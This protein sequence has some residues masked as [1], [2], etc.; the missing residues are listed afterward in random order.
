[1]PTIDYSVIE[2]LEQFMGDQAE[3]VTLIDLFLDLAPEQ[4]NQVTQ[5]WESRD[6][7]VLSRCA[8]SL[9]SSASNLGAV[10]LARRCSELEQGRR[11]PED[12]SQ[13]EQVVLYQAVRELLFNVARHARADVVGIRLA[14][15]DSQ[16]RLEVVDDGVGFDSSRLGIQNSEGGGFGLFAIRERLERLGGDLV[17]ESSPEQGTR[18]ALRVPLDRS[19]AGE[20]QEAS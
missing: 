6:L 11:W 15:K 19:T 20:Q 9:K 10:E 7:Q 2:K 4:V 8:H 3:I 13:R 5:A 18:V 17:V 14:L 1:M 16:L 12:L